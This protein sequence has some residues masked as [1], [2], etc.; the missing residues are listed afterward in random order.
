MTGKSGSFDQHT[1]DFLSVFEAED[2]RHVI[3]YSKYMSSLDA[4]VI[5][6]MARKAACVF[7]CFESLGMT[8]RP[9][10]VTTD[11]ILTFNTSWLKGKKVALVDDALISGTTLYSTRNQVASAGANVTVHTLFINNEWYAE[12]LIV[13]DHNFVRLSDVSAS[14]LSS[15]LVDAMSIVPR[16]YSID[17]PLFES[18]TIRSS[19][20][21]VLCSI[22]GWVCFDVSTTLQKQHGVFSYTV[23]P[24]IIRLR[25]LGVLLGW[26]ISKR[27]LCKIRIYGR[28]FGPNIKISIL[29]IVA[30]GPIKNNEVNALFES[31]LEEH[32][33]GKN[34]LS[35]M[36]VSGGAKFQ[37]IQFLMAHRLAERWVS[38]LQSILP[39]AFSNPSL[40]ID[41]VS[42]LFPPEFAATIVDCCTCKQAVFKHADSSSISFEEPECETTDI[43]SVFEVQEILAEKF[44]S[45]YFEKELPARKIVKKLG[46]DAFKD[47][48]WKELV[49]RLHDGFTFPQLK[50]CIPIDS[51][52]DRTLL[53]SNFLDLSIDRGAVVPI[54]AK[55]RSEDNKAEDIYYRAYRHGE[56]II[57]TLREERLLLTMLREFL[58]SSGRKIIPPTWME[59]L[60]V[61]FI[62][63]GINAGFLNPYYGELRDPRGGIG[64]ATP[65]VGVTNYLHGAVTQRNVNHL[66]EFDPSA[67]FCNM[68]CRRK[69]LQKHYGDKKMDRKYR[70]LKGYSLGE[71]PTAPVNIKEENLAKRLGR[72]IGEISYKGKNA[73]GKNA[74]LDINKLTLIA[75][76]LIA[77]DSLL[78]LAAELNIF[79]RFWKNHVDEFN[80]IERKNVVCDLAC[81]LR[82]KNTAPGQAWTAINN[83]RWKFKSSLRH[84]AERY[85]ESI[86][87]YYKSIDIEKSESWYDFW[88]DL[89][90]VEES[91]D[92][93]VAKRY[94][95]RAG[96][97]VLVLN[98]LIR[99][100]ECQVFNRYECNGMKGCDE[101]AI[102]TILKEIT[103]EGVRTK[104]EKVCNSLMS[105][106]ISLNDIVHDTVKCISQY[107][108]QAYS[109]LSFIKKVV[110]PKG[111]FK[112]VSYFPYTLGIYIQDST[113][114]AHVM[115]KVYSVVDAINKRLRKKP[116][117]KMYH[118][119]QRSIAVT[120]IEDRLL[121]VNDNTRDLGLIQ[122][123]AKGTEVLRWL[124]HFTFKIRRELSDQQGVSYVIFS[125]LPKHLQPFLVGGDDRLGNSDFDE[126]CLW[127]SSVVRETEG[128]LFHF[129]S[130]SEGQDFV[131]QEVEDNLGGTIIEDKRSMVKI[132]EYSER[133]SIKA[134][135]TMRG[136]VLEKGQKLTDV[137][138]VL[139]TARELRGV[140]DFFDTQGGFKRGPGKQSGRTY[141]K[142]ILPLNRDTQTITLIVT[143]A[144]QQGQQAIMSAV[145]AL[146]KEARPRIVVLLG[147]AGSIDD[148]LE[149]GD[150]VVGDNVIFYEDR[151]E[152]DKGTTR[153]LNSKSVPA[154]TLDKSALFFADHGDPAVLTGK[155]GDQFNVIPAPIGSG[156]AILKAEIHEIRDYLKSM[157]YRTA[158]IEKEAAG[159]LQYFFEES[160]DKE[161]ETEGVFIIRGV[162]DSADPDK[163]D[164][165]QEK[166]AFNGMVVLHELLKSVNR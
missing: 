94:L 80:A 38:K 40:D 29:P 131:S 9:T 118:Q 28:L 74:P 12:K 122:V 82:R 111:K 78:A 133:F 67:S 73:N 30:L 159:F 31:V 72:R 116:M 105:S 119:K 42:L 99:V 3:E 163:D 60:L 89:E 141:L 52:S 161:V 2:K 109:V 68:L 115:S 51:G 92:S 11:R 97:L 84:L 112:T 83:G 33:K 93:K 48:K 145:H 164:S 77:E 47:T 88:P 20:I 113:N 54:S 139:I 117:P 55:L 34:S 56:E 17:Y 62:K 81:E 4:D 146:V 59:K 22:P 36:C 166:A 155:D 64:T 156:E 147:I 65:I 87:E 16:P 18:M 149:L 91:E 19:D 100:W 15:N 130:S 134:F 110:E 70:P 153:K 13:P 102:S 124:M 57:V 53:V 137:G 27:G 154:W 120:G 79:V 85:V 123:A 128:Q 66:Y 144:I 75:T 43:N 151:V 35:E 160:L 61:L 148:S 114:R 8:K 25:E 39:Y 107:A 76:C 104:V 106:D 138:V 126:L 157:D 46:V 143:K 121:V 26:N 96:D 14:Q 10:I 49:N 50:S 23:Q 152:T 69:R 127:C 37:F 44:K 41:E 58:S 5:M 90:T 136:V 86:G 71:F 108:K 125:G 162:S 6:L 158:V 135:S 7:R 101:T 21:E 45:L 103:D 140:Q 142:A 1:E 32:P 98:V 132:D 63:R 150:V 129:F 95:R 165:C 24:N